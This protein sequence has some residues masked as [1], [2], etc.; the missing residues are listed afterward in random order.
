MTRWRIFMIFMN[1]WIMHFYS[2]LLCIVLHPKR[3]TIMLGGGGGGLSSTATSVQHPLG[4]CESCHRK[5]VPVRSPH[6]SYRWR[7][8]RV[9]EPIK[10]IL[11][12]I[13]RKY[14]VWSCK[15]LS[16]RYKYMQWIYQRC[17]LHT[18][19]FSSTCTCFSYFIST[20]QQDLFFL[21]QVFQIYF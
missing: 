21:Q 1:E 14:A 15:T 16:C 4:W 5:T 19:L 11:T 17:V 18:C 2:A 3:F 20:D 10:W 12:I 7:G 8:E 6:I 9:I 13:C